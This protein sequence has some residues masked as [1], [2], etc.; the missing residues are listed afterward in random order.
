MLLVLHV[1]FSDIINFVFI[2]PSW[3]STTVSMVGKFFI[4]I[5]FGI[6]YIFSN[7][8]FPTVVRNIAL[9]SASVCARI[10]SFISPFMRELVSFDSV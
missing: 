9:G 6:I 8:V 3:L 4:T 7:E 5:S 1:Y 2:D 10:G